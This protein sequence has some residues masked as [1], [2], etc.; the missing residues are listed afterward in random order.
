MKQVM[1][2]LT[3]IIVTWL[4]SH[5]MASTP[6]DLHSSWNQ[7]GGA[8]YNDIW[9]YTDQEGREYALLGVRNG[10]SIILLED[11]LPPREI[12]FIPSAH[13]LWKDIKTYGHYAYTVNESGGGLQ[14]IDL[15]NLP[16]SAQLVRNYTGFQTS[17]NIFIDKENHRLYAEGNHAVPVRILSLEDPT[18]PI[19]IGSFGVECHD[20]YVRDNIAYISEGGHGTIGIFDTTNA[21]DPQ[22]VKRF[23]IP[24]AG[25]VHNAWLSDDGDYLMTTE[26]T[27]GKT[28]KY[29]DISDLNHISAGRTIKIVQ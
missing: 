24:N 3:G 26:E 8:K 4:G 25:Y 21:S 6:L 29:W 22:L 15:S 27:T 19:Q 7:R 13:S 10:T 9:G 12:S 2:K 14:I 17:H 18:R 1:K 28:V 23:Q 16:H 20:I 11:E 5:L